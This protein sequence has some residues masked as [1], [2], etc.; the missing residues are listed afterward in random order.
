MGKKISVA[1]VLIFNNFSKEGYKSILE[2]EDGTLHEYTSVGPGRWQADPYAQ[3]KHIGTKDFT[4]R[5]I[6]CTKLCF[7]WRKYDVLFVDSAITGLLVPI[8]SFLIKGHRKL[9]IASFNV[10]RRRKGFWKW[11][12][13]VVYQQVDHFFV[14]SKYDIHLAKQLY[15]IPEQRF[16]Y[17]PFVRATPAVGESQDIYMFKDKRPF[18]LSF[19]GNA[20]DYGTFFQAIKETDLSAI[21]VA[22]EYNLE[23]L[24]IPDNVRAFFNIP[25]EECDQL[26]GKC[27]FTVF[28][29]DGS[30]P[31]CGQISLVTSFML[32][33]PTICTD[34]VGVHDYV[35]DGENGL[36]V[37][38]ADAGDLRTKMLKL[39]SNQQLYAKLSSG[40][41]SWAS[42]NADP[43]KLQHMVDKLVTELVS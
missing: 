21:V 43:A 14:H 23:G 40:A 29:F 17:R 31:S 27:M 10:P 7:L 2:M 26:V 35:S 19:G 33:K 8:L 32:G 16:T 24:I 5:I 11:L 37:E 34:I 28:T 4:C 36:L 22:R 25:L 38:M 1:K 15:Q 6:A 39:A 20:R 13:R 9:V 42:E 30:E 3:K 18:I 41:R 12:G